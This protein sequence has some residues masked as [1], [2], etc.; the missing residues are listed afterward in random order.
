MCPEELE[1]TRFVSGF[2]RA[3]VA[4]LVVEKASGNILTLDT[5]KNT[6]LSISQI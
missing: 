1:E 4:C 5:A 3:I 6:L 2:E